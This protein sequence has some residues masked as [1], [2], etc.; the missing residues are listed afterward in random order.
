MRKIKKIDWNHRAMIYNC[1]NV[2]ADGSQISE[3]RKNKIRSLYLKIIDGVP[4]EREGNYDFK[5]LDGKDLVLEDP[6]WMD[7][8]EALPALK[9]PT[10]FMEFE[11]EKILKQVNEAKEVNK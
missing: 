7:L 2:N 1:I 4:H 11:K 9:Y 5:P 10:V 6:E 3:E 8:R